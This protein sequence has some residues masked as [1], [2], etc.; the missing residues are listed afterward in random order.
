MLREEKFNP[1]LTKRTLFLSAAGSFL[2]NERTELKLQ[3]EEIQ[4]PK[5]VMQRVGLTNTA[6]MEVAL[7]GHRL[8]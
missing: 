8:V 3:T 5:L 6:E 1:N 2:M 7:D 4:A